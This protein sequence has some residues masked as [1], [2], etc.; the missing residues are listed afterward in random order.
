M[1]DY[2]EMYLA[3]FRATEQAVDT[4]IQ[5]QQKCEELYVEQ[6]QVDLKVFSQIRQTDEKNDS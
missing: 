1:P 6:G 4:L 2:R 5:A 3:L